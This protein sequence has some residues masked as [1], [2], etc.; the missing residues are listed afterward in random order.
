[1]CAIAG[2]VSTRCNRATLNKMGDILSYRG[3]DETGLFYEHNVG[4]INKRLSIID[5]KNGKQPAFNEN[6]DIAVVFNGEIFN[7]LELRKSLEVR[8]HVI[9]NNSDTAILPHLYEEYGLAMFEN[10]NGQFAI[11]I[12]DKKLNKLIL[13][14]DRLGVVPLFYFFQNREF[15]FASEV[16]AI[17]ASGRAPSV[18][19]YEAFRDVFTY[20]SPQHDRTMFEGVKSVLPGQYLVVEDGKITK[21]K[22]YK[23]MFKKPDE[24]IDFNTARQG[25]EDLLLKAV[26]KRLM[27]DV[28]ISTYLSGGLDSSLITSIVA[29]HF[30]SSVEAFSVNFEDTRF[31]EGDYQKQVCDMLGIK[32]HAILFKNTDFA[33]LINQIIWHSEVP[34]LRGG[35][36]PL[37]KLSQLAGANNI[38]VVLSGEGSDELLGGYDIFKETKIRNYL[39]KYP[40][41][42]NRVKLLKRINGFSD[43][44]FES[45]KAGSL[46]YFYLHNNEDEL[47]QSHFLRW[48]QIGFFERFVSD[49]ALMIFRRQKSRNYADRLGFECIEQSKEWSPIQKSQYI[50]ADTFLSR[51]LLSTQGDRMSMAHSV[52]ARFPFLDDELVGYCMALNDRYKIKAL[53]EKYI[54]KKIAE[55]Y[56]P[57]D[58]INRKKFPYRSPVD[59]KKVLSDSYMKY[60]LSDEKISQ[61]NLFNVAKVKGFINGIMKKD[62]LSEREIMLFMGILTTQILCSLFNIE[63]QMETAISGGYSCV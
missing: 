6:Q 1:M 44:R 22:Y 36:V 56:L 52:E 40:D 11:A 8:G 25:L 53:N 20:W 55:K 27:G 43:S 48:R 15:V 10:L 62:V 30:N 33:E 29:K 24:R 41:S 31:D 13:A 63:T 47:F 49:N 35:P 39:K 46:G 14:R 4:L 45:A 50:E 18:L 34:L 7:H 37:F 38:K 9:S 58:L 3:P 28:K 17:L 23:L 42:E 16:K 2:F 61:L 12:Y 21:N 57:K 5:L 54:L 51:Y 32:R 26:E 19:C 59:V 60:M